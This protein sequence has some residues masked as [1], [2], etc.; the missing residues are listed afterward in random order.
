MLG[1]GYKGTGPAMNDLLGGQF[2]IMCDQTT[3]TTNQI[4]SGKIKGYAVTTKTKVS[5][6][7][8]LPT[9]D[10][11]AIKDFDLSIWH[12]MWAPKGLPKDVTDKLVA[13]LQTALK[14]PKIVE[15]MAGLGTEPVAAELATPAA[16]KS[17]LTAEV[18]KWGAVIK[19]AGVKAN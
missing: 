15:R 11:T 3:N 14:D 1:V 19:A 4:K 8:D 17:H 7:P 9:L 13:A 18:A 2:E 5:S 12:A 16:L 6:V 10:S